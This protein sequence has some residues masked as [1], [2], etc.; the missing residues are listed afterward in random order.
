MLFL[1][2]LTQNIISNLFTISMMINHSPY[3]YYYDKLVIRTL[4]VSRN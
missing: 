2:I 1:N 4:G 3:L